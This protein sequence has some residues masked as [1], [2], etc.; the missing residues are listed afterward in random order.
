MAGRK[1][2]GLTGTSVALTGERATLAA[3]V[4]EAALGTAGWAGRIFSPQEVFPSR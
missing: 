2:G 1:A 4:A 3:E